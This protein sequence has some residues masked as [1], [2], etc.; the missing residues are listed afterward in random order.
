[1]ISGLGVTNLEKQGPQCI[2]EQGAK[3]QCAV[4]QSAPA[5]ARSLFG[6]W[7]EI[8]SNEFPSSDNRPSSGSYPSGTLAFIVL[9]GLREGHLTLFHLQMLTD[10]ALALITLQAQPFHLH[11]GPCVPRCAAGGE[12]PPRPG[13]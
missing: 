2:L 12:L 3:F 8:S 13:R 1:M 9:M 7:S 10:P 6:P 11:Q 5:P 4:A